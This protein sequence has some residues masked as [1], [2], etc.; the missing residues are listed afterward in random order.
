MVDGLITINGKQY[1]IKYD[2]N[3]ICEMKLDGLDVMAMSNGQ[4]ELDF[5]QLR[6]LFYYGLK[7]IQRD[8]IKTKE[9]AGDVMSAY[10]ECEGSIEELTNIMVNALVRSLG[11][12]EGK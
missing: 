6:S 9:D 5:I 8:Q 7:K 3:I 12:K 2:M 1:F 10:L 4:M 11:F